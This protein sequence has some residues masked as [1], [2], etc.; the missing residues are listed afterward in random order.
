MTIE[1]ARQWAKTALEM[2]DSIRADVC[3]HLPEFHF[4]DISVEDFVKSHLPDLPDVPNLTD[5]RSHLPDMPDMRSHLPDMADMR[6]HLPDFADMRSKLE[7]VRTRF[8]D[9]DFQQPLNYVPTLSNHLQKLHSHL[10]SMEL[11]STLDVLPL[12]PSTM[13]SDLLDALLSSELVTDLLNATPDEVEIEDAF[14]KT[15]KEVADAIKRSFEGVRL[16]KYS[17]LPQQWKN[18]PFVTHGYR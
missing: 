16:I 2:L 10:S 14:E 12:A 9:I 5:M 8:N 7:D 17:D 15:A 1:E 18:N 3:S 11:P 13:L 6:S 4:A